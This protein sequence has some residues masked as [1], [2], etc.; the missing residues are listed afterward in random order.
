MSNLFPSRSESVCK[1]GEAA[2]PLYVLGLPYTNAAA[3]FWS[4]LLSEAQSAFPRLQSIELSCPCGVRLT[5]N[6]LFPNI[7]TDADFDAA[8]LDDSEKAMADAV[9]ALEL[10]GAPSSVAVEVSFGDNEQFSCIL[11]EECVDA[12]T[13]PYLV[14]WPLEWG[15]VPFSEWNS[16]SVSGKF[17][18]TD[19][20]RDIFYR[21]TFEL[22]RRPLSEGLYQLSCLLHSSP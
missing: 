4:A 22:R 1:G 12:E 13:L 15:G 11:P 6:M 18:G 9:S 14:V 16:D 5:R 2:D 20:K 3:K 21:L 8:Q 10:M 7:V 19:R 17:E